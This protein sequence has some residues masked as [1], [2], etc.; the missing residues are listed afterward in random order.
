MKTKLLI[1]MVLSAAFLPVN[2]QELDLETCLRM[3]DTANIE[4]VNARL[5]IAKNKK[6]INAYLSARLPK[7]TATGDYKYN[8]I[9][10]GQLV[11][12]QFF[13]GAPGSYATVAFGVPYNLSNTI[14]LQQIL[15]NPQVNYG[16]NSLKIQQEVVEI[17][18]R[19][20]TR[21]TKHQVAST[22]FNLQA[23]GKQLE[24]VD[25]NI[26][27]ME[28][29]I[30]N[31]EAMVKQEMVMQ[32]EADKLKIQRL[33]LV[34]TKQTLEANQD[35]LER[36]LKILIGIPDEQEIKLAS[37]ELVRQSILVDNSEVSYPEVDLVKAQIKL[38]EEEH[39]GTNMSYLPSLSLYGSYNYTYNMKPSDNV[40]K[41]IESA[42]V[43]L[44]LDW[45]L[46]DGLEKMN[47]QKVNKINQMR[48]ENQESYLKQQ[49]DIQT[50]NAR[51]QIDIQLNS[52]MISQEQLG[53]AQ[54]VYRQSELQYAQGVI[55]SNDLI[56]A[57]NALQEAQTNVVLAYVKLRQAEL[58]YLKATGK[59]Q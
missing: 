52:L 39:S 19:I 4:I 7:I 14:Q 57:E 8:A 33:N 29:L 35:Q 6:Q 34:N 56:Q 36:L 37:D 42:F 59:I 1:T 12:A 55:N 10:P 22:Y 2:A 5:D 58:D 41:G 53:L 32:T 51:K 46:F 27:N 44:R 49:L 15:Y 28:R 21:D 54:N 25:T 24:F 3:A 48:L 31:L 50:S 40:R 23:L 47:K 43:G 30:H 26:L 45:T 17:Q 16:I 9:I 38:N 20:T 11:P 18:E 13:G